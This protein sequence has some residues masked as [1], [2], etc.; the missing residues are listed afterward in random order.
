ML[1]SAVRNAVL[2]FVS[3]TIEAPDGRQHQ[4][5]IVLHPGAVTVVAIRPD[6]R[7][8]LV[9]QYR[10]GHPCLC[11]LWAEYACMVGR[12]GRNGS[13]GNYPNV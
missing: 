11:L 7:V 4:R 8:L 9:R 3:D 1:G 6:G 2:A 10:H 13:L 12:V 5:E